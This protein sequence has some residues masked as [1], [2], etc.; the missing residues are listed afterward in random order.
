MDILVDLGNP[1][2]PKY[3]SESNRQK[4]LTHL[5]FRQKHLRQ[6]KR[7][8]WEPQAQQRHH[9]DNNPSY[10]DNNPSYNPSCN[11]NIIKEHSLF[12]STNLWEGK[13]TLGYSPVVWY[14][15]SHLFAL[16]SSH[17]SLIFHLLGSC[18]SPAPPPVFAHTL[19]SF[20]LFLIPSNLLSS[21]LTSSPFFFLWHYSCLA[22]H[23]RKHLKHHA[24]GLQQCVWLYR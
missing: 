3:T 16:V 1:N 21:P 8:N 4:T 11:N 12:Q 22:G 2:M 17:L 14:L 9:N 7:N 19:F 24:I 6:Q 5:Y 20:L 23:N 15:F 18:L 13:K 10:N